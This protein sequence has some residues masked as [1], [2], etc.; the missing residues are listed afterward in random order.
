MLQSFFKIKTDVRDLSYVNPKIGYSYHIL[1]IPIGEWE[2]NGFQCNVISIAVC[3]FF[4]DLPSFSIMIVWCND[5]YISVTEIP[6]YLSPKYFRMKILYYRIDVLTQYSFGFSL[7]NYFL[8]FCYPWGSSV[9]ERQESDYGTASFL[10][11]NQ[12][13]LGERSCFLVLLEQAILS[14]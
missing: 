6:P 1:Y 12:W 13:A 2:A 5:I 7:G 3:G 4:C 9:T 10:K 11:K 8:L 14:S